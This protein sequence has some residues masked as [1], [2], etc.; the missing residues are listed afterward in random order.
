MQPQATVLQLH[1]GQS[2]AAVGQCYAALKSTVGYFQSQ[3]FA[4]NQ[5]GAE[6]AIATHDDGRLLQRDFEAIRRDA[7]QRNQQAQFALALDHV[8]GRLPARH[9][10]ALADTEELA[11]EPVCALKQLDRL[12]QHPCHWVLASH[13]SIS[14]LRTADLRMTGLTSRSSQP[15]QFPKP[16]TSTV[17]ERYAQH[18]WEDL[19]IRKNREGLPIDGKPNIGLS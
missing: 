4:S 10:A 1:V 16:S 8:H 17:L 14:L 3:N 7:G 11:L 13:E 19:T 12:G 18:R 6:G 5:P 15:H 2:I 9:H